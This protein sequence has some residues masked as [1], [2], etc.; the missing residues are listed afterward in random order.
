MSE[1][2]EVV[3]S[4]DLRRGTFHADRT[5][6]SRD[7]LL[8]CRASEIVCGICIFIGFATRPAA[9]PM[10]TIVIAALAATRL[11]LLS[12][13]SFWEF[14]YPVRIEFA[15]LMSSMFLLIRGGGLWSPDTKI[16]KRRIEREIY[17]AQSRRNRCQD[18]SIADKEGRL[19]PAF[20]LIVDSFYSTG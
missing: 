3:A 2:T 15:L 5:A 9:I 7:S 19:M 14:A 6:L 13:S 17:T 16:E 10:I 1:A 4:N 20:H 8:C 11:P 18:R 12:T